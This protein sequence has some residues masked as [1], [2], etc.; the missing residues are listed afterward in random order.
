[1]NGWTH[2]P[3]PCLT[4]AVGLRHQRLL[5]HF[6]HQLAVD[7]PPQVLHTQQARES[8]GHWRGANHRRGN[9]PSPAWAAPQTRAHRLA[10]ARDA[11]PPW[12]R[13]MPRSP[14]NKASGCMHAWALKGGGASRITA[15]AQR[16]S[17]G[18]QSTPHVRMPLKKSA[19]RSDTADMLSWYCSQAEGSHEEGRVRRACAC[20]MLRCPALRGSTAL[21][22]DRCPRPTACHTHLVSWALELA[23][24]R[25][26]VRPEGLCVAACAGGQAQGC[27]AL[28]GSPAT[29]GP[30]PN[31]STKARHAAVS[32][33]TLPPACLAQV[34]DRSTP[35]YCTPP[36][37]G[38]SHQLTPSGISGA[39]C[40]V[41][42][43]CAGSAPPA[44]LL[45]GT[46]AR[47][48]GLSCWTAGEGW[49][50]Q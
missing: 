19:V 23:P 37:A 16:T 47:D 39:I 29:R 20:P 11:S 17:P 22:G 27:P 18:R 50:G 41:W 21:P 46:E 40:S 5:I 43:A 38:P 1:M 49:R 13:P 26:A 45:R 36:L 8:R 9:A 30:V 34:C 25:I 48:N 10:P 6:I 7:V 42:L 2:P 12:R 14:K 4:C 15:A 44:E 24:P 31:A 28:S 35:G 33:A 32:H 3:T